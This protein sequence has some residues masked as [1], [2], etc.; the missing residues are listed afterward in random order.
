MQRRRAKHQ[1]NYAA[2]LKCFFNLKFLTQFSDKE[3]LQKDAIEFSIFGNERKIM[4][5]LPNKG[6]R[7]Q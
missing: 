1:N 5:S 4:T 2:I 7:K 6:D 3:Y